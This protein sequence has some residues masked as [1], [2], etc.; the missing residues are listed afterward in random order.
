MALL[1]PIDNGNMYKDY[2]RWNPIIGCRHGCTYCSIKRMENRVNKKDEPIKNDM[3]TPGF[4]EHYLKDDLGEGRKIFVGSSSDSWGEWVPAEW[5]TTMLRHCRSYPWNEYLWMTKNPDGYL[6][7]LLCQQGHFPPKF[8]LGATIETDDGDIL[9]PYT[10]CLITPAPCNR[11]EAMREIRR[12]FPDVE[13]VLSLEPLL[14]FNLD[15]FVT[16]VEAIGPKKVW[17]GADSGKNGMPEPE[18]EKV[19]ALITQLARFTVVI[20]KKNLSRLLGEE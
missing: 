17:V 19:R 10:N 2:W 7:W 12:R 4:R 5:I 6:A 15:N 18:P 14:D 8:M 13:A 1:K 16:M 9:A 11:A 3:T 20:E